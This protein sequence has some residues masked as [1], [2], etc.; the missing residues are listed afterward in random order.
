MIGIGISLWQAAL[1]GG[2]SPPAETFRILW[3][4]GD[5]LAWDDGDLI[6]WDD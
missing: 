2:G 3:D 6:A 5:T 1:G 4:D